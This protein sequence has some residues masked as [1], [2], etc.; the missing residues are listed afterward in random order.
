MIRAL[1]RLA[2]DERGH[3]AIELAL[4][5]PVLVALLVVGVDGWTQMRQASQM[6]S[7]LQ[8]GARYYQLGGSSDT[9]AQATALASWVA[10]P[11]DA[12]LNVSRACLCGTTANACTGVCPDQSQPAIDVTL[13]AAGTF[14]GTTYTRAMTQT[15]VVRVR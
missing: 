9:T 5:L 11:P 10:P 2:G 12:A 14:T 3:A 13:T 4:L 8:T 15:E 6:R 7:A 1:K